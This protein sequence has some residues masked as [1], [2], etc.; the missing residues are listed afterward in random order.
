MINLLSSSE[1]KS[2]SSLTLNH[3]WLWLWRHFLFAWNL[4]F[5]NLS[6]CFFISE[7]VIVFMI[8]FNA[9][10]LCQPI[11]TE[12]VFNILTNFALFLLVCLKFYCRTCGTMTFYM[13]QHRNLLWFLLDLFLTCNFLRITCSI[14]V[15]I[16]KFLFYL[17]FT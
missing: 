5:S 1:T 7:V 10:L 11:Q 4:I 15:Y 16:W 3:P 2:P 12:L 8:L 13:K 6:S 9:M 14:S 17:Q